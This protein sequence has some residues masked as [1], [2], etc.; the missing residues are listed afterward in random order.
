MELRNKNVLFRKEEGLGLLTL[1]RPEKLNAL[2]VPLIEEFGEVLD[3]IREDDEIGVVI[4]TGEGRAFSV[5]ADI[6]VIEHLGSPEAFRKDMKKLWHKNFDSIEEMEKLFIAALNGV[7]LGGGL[8][9]ALACDLRVAAE[10]ISLGLPEINFGLIPDA[11]GTIRLA[12]LIG[13]GMAKELILSG[14]LI[15]CEE[16]NGLGLVNRVLPSQNFLEEVFHYASKFVNKS[17]VA[18]GLGKVAVNKCLNQDIKSGLEDAI[19]IQ[20]ILLETPEYQEAVKAFKEKQKTR[21]KGTKTKE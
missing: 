3:V 5:G 10:G 9:L 14:E 8:E 12:R 4:I 2:N 20:S 6:D 13:P 15:P 11:G 19:I 16:A 1:N 17:A 18:V 21:S 7:T